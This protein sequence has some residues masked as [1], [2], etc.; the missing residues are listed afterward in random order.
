[1]S[2]FQQVI[3]EFR[4][5]RLKVYREDPDQIIRDTNSANETARD[6]VGRWIYELIQNADDAEASQLLVRVTGEAIYVADNGKGLAPATIKSLSGTH[7][8]VKPAGAIGRKGLG[9]K[10]VYAITRTP[11]IFSHEDGLIFCPERSVA[12]LQEHGIATSKIPYQWLPF[13]LSRRTDEQHDEVLASLRE[14]R[15]VVKLPLTNSSVAAEVVESLCAL[16]AYVLLTFRHLRQLQVATNDQDK[17]FSVRMTVWPNN[18]TE[19]NI[20]DTRQSQSQH[21]R[22]AKAL[23]NPPPE[24][25]IEFEDEDDRRRVAEVS[26]AV[27]TMLNA[28]GQVTP[29]SAPIMLHVYYPTEE[30]A[31]IPALLHADFVVKSDRTKI[32][33][34]FQFNAWLSGKLAAH[35]VDCVQQ[36]Y[37]DSAPAANLRLLLLTGDFANSDTATNLWDRIEACAKSVLKL[38]DASGKLVLTLDIACRVATS[39][40]P[41]LARQISAKCGY[42]SRLVHPS[43][44]ADTQARRVLDKLGCAKLTDDDLFAAIAGAPDEIARDAD[45]VWTC[46]RWVAAWAAAQRQQDWRPDARNGRLT[47]LRK[48]RILPV[49]GQTITRESVGTNVLTWRDATFQ[50]AMPEWMPL[51][52]VD[53]WLRD[54]LLSAPTDSPLQVLLAELGVEEPTQKLL[55]KAVAHAI[56]DFWKTKQGDASRF[57]GILEASN[58]HEQFDAS[59]T[60]QRCPIRATIEGKPGEFFVEARRAYFEIGRAHV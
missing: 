7:L 20:T 5:R 15:T 41:E 19:W 51:S 21:W 16:P 47:Q 12:W 23:L 34:D 38:P 45:W 56:A 8:S 30:P 40:A 35:V 4:E 60:L 6:H 31:P 14:M 52:F 37:S 25:L 26:V 10:S 55:L 46:W 44:E 18:E 36:W 13:W 3:E 58:F 57:L 29:L 27:A 43:L 11:Q 42:A 22:L 9:F 39:V 32:V 53:D 48:T 28:E 59:E 17:S 33:P 50:L 24:T 49:S 1:M 54:K 2:K